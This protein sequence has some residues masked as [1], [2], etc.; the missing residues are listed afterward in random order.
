[1]PKLPPTQMQRRAK[2]PSK[3][4][5]RSSTERCAICPFMD[6]A[7]E[8]GKI[9]D[10]SEPATVGQEAHRIVA[11]VLE[12][13]KIDG[14]GMDLAQYLREE[15]P[16]A[17][18]DI[19]PQVIQA[20]IWLC[21]RFK[22]PR[23]NPWNIVGVEKQYS[24]VFWEATDAEGPTII[25]QCFDLVVAGRNEESLIVQDWKS[26]R[27]R[28]SKD[29]AYNAYQTQHGCFL[30]FKEMP[31][32]QE[33]HWT[34][35]QTRF[36]TGRT[37]VKLTREWDYHNFQGRIAEALRLKQSG[38]KEAWP[39]PEKCD[40]CRVITIC[41]HALKD[42]V[43]FQKDKVGHLQRH[44][45]LKALVSKMGSTMTTYCK[46]TGE[47]ITANGKSWKPKPRENVI[48]GDCKDEGD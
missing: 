8:S 20:C 13:Y 36:E 29:D 47:T 33:I 32:V 21:Y 10:I 9:Q 24:T 17:R 35:D 5:D 11:E 34:Y 15:L 27:L 46:K 45:V 39:L 44:R 18:P 2:L 23:F 3:Y 7:I 12:V 31:S 37:Y 38:S 14:E 22:Y 30:L 6:W 16:K 28:Y 26:G 43:D 25:T 19:Q 42:S 40:W 4:Y 48:Y 1:M 41:P